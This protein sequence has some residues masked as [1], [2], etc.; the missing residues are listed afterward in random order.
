MER[1]II[2]GFGVLLSLVL[3]KWIS[4]R[5]KGKEYDSWYNDLLTSDKYKVKGQYD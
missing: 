2:I 3:V 5:K 4:L 1:Y